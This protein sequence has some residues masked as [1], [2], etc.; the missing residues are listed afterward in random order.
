MKHSCFPER[1][2]LHFTSLIG[3]VAETHFGGF[4]MSVT[5][6]KQPS[7]FVPLAMSF[8]AL[9]MVVGHAAL[10]GVVREADEGIPAHIFQLLMAAQVPVVAVFAVKWLPRAPRQALHVLALQASAALAAI[11][12]VFLLT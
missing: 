5:T 9:A 8:A 7:A 10:Y 1:G 2:K 4:E 3:S 12:A 11:A 6:L